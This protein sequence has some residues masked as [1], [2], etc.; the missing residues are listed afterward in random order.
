MPTSMLQREEDR[1]RERERYREEK[2]KLLITIVVD[3]VTTLIFSNKPTVV[4]H[5]LSSLTKLNMHDSGSKYQQ[6]TPTF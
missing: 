3:A 4:S 5:S 1:Q 6:H 2:E